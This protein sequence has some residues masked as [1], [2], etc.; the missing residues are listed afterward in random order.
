[1]I[2]PHPLDKWTGVSIHFPY[3][4]FKSFFWLYL[5]YRKFHEGRDYTV[6]LTTLSLVPRTVFDI[7]EIVHELWQTGWYPRELLTN[8]C[9]F[10]PVFGTLCLSPSCEH[11]AYQVTIPLFAEEAPSA[12]IPCPGEQAVNSGKG[13]KENTIKE[14]SS[15]PGASAS[16]NE[17]FGSFLSACEGGFKMQH[18]MWGYL[19]SDLTVWPIFMPALKLFGLWPS[20]PVILF[21]LA[22]RST[23]VVRFDSVWHSVPIPSSLK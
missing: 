10:C 14:W 17:T 23:C 19:N 7:K 22:E 11:V 8:M 21:G 6:L 4:Q 2:S 18:V 9:L 12:R 16:Q 5:K 15:F 13:R 1:M 20:A 3:L